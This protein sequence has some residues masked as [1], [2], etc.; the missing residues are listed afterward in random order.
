M[1][2]K[3][4]GFTLIETLVTVALVTILAAAFLP[5]LVDSADRELA[6]RAALTLEELADAIT[7][8]RFDNQDWPQ[9]LSQLSTPITTADQNICGQ[10]YNNG[11]VSN[12]DGPY[13]P[14]L[15]PPSGMPVGIGTVRNLMGRVVLSGNPNSGGAISQVVIFVDGVPE[16]AALELNGI[17]D[18]DGSGA[19][20]TIRW[21]APDASGLTTV[22][23]LRTI[24][25]C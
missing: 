4:C 15:F 23:W 25:G 24:K 13:Y 11:R 2:T 8:A 20:G 1:R 19:T 22:S 18:A 7:T 10:N 17:V 21:S 14:R 3:R 9:K 6:L 16:E 5:N 12:W